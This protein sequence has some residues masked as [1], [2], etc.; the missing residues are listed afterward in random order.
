MGSLKLILVPLNDISSLRHVNHT[1]QLGD[2]GKLAESAIS[3]T[4]HVANKT[5]K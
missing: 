4:L 3:P 2:F 5:V 1:T